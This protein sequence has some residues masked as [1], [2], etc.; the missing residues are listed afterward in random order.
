MKFE[1]QNCPNLTVCVSLS[2]DE[3]EDE[4]EEEKEE[5]RR[6]R[7]R[8]RRVD[9]AHRLQTRLTT[10]NTGLSLLKSPPV[11]LSPLL[12]LERGSCRKVCHP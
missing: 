11:S 9:N 6:R 10:M 12:N 3:D 1:E 7:R 8:K 4:D 2:E 5:E